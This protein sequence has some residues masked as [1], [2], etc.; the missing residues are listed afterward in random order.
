MIGVLI[1][2]R[3]STYTQALTRLNEEFKTELGEYV[4][5][6]IK[7]NVYLVIKPKEATK[8]DLDKTNVIGGGDQGSRPFLTMYTMIV[9]SKGESTAK[10]IDIEISGKDAEVVLAAAKS[11]GADFDDKK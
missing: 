4:I 3:G 5:K 6:A 2:K 9:D 8:E 11:A 10:D 7:S 1:P